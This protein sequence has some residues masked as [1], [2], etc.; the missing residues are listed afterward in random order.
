MIASNLAAILAM[1]LVTYLTRVGGYVFL[2]NRSLGWRAKAVMDA[3]SGCVLITVIAPDF[4]T[5]R[6]ADLMALL[7]AAVAASRLP[8][9]PTVVIAIA[10][11]GLLRAILP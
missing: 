1:A 4:V 3:A 9:L 6:P 5:G 10:A 11:A 8:L 7:L 2:R